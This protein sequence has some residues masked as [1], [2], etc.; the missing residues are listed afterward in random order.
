METSSARGLPQIREAVIYEAKISLLVT[1]SDVS[2]LL[3]ADESSI[4]RLSANA[5]T[6]WVTSF[7]IDEAGDLEGCSICSVG[8]VTA[9][10]SQYDSYCA[11]GS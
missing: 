6:F 1:P 5:S 11:D 3:I 8:R 7:G 2:S 9:R 10:S 4:W